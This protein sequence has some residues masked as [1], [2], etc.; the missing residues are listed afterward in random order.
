MHFKEVISNVHIE[1]DEIMVSFD[2]LSLFTY[3]PIDEAIS[4]IHGRLLGD[5]TLMDRT[6]LAPAEFLSYWRCAYGLPISV[7][8]G[9]S[10]NR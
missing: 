1:D 2:V 3:V 6:S 8:E 9:S 4:V 7:I 10:T 5:V